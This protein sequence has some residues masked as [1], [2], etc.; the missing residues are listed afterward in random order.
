M[1]K[2]VGN[3]MA[4]YQSISKHA[5]SL[6]FTTNYDHHAMQCKLQVASC[7]KQQTLFLAT[8]TYSDLTH[9]S[10]C[11]LHCIHM[12]HHNKVLM[13]HFSIIKQHSGFETELGKGVGKQRH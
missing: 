12:Y 9:Q 11:T 2:I 13:V 8:Q 10:P 6:Q 4:Q 1:A 7:N 5:T 3:L